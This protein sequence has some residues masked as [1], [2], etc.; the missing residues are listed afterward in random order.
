M[1]SRHMLIYLAGRHS[2]RHYWVRQLTAVID[3][4]AKEPTT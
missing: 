2:G 4:D 1:V 3:I